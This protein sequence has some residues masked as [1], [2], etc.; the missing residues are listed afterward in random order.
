MRPRL[1]LELGVAKK[2]DDLHAK[3]GGKTR[4]RVKGSPRVPP[5]KTFKRLSIALLLALVVYVFVH[6]IPTDLGPQDKRHPSYVYPSTNG[7]PGAPA[8]PISPRPAVADDGPSQGA[9]VARDY[10]GPVRFLELA[11]TLHAITDTKGTAPVNKNVLFM[12]STL[13]SASKMLPIACEMGRELRSYVHFALVSRDEIPIKQ[14][15]DINGIGD[16]CQMIYHDARPEFSSMSTDERFEKAVGRSLYHINNYMHPQAVIVDSEAE[17]SLFLKAIRAQ[18]AKIS[19]SAPVIELPAGAEERLSWL[20]KL[21]AASLLRWNRAS[22]DILIHAHADASGSLI[23]LLKSLSDADYSACATPH[24][25][26]ELPEKIDPPTRQFLENFQWPPRSIP[27]PT[28]LTQLTLRHRISG[29]GLSEEESSVQFL[30]SFWPA[31]PAYSHVL[32]LSPQVELSTNYFH[33]LKLALLEYHYSS[34]VLGSGWDKRLLGISLDLPSTYLSGSGPFTAPTRSPEETQSPESRTET[35]APGPFLWQ[36]PNS[37]AMLFTG[38]RWLEL[39]GFVSRSLEAQH[40]AETP[41][42]LLSEKSVS[43]DHPAWL[44]HVLRLCRAQGYWTLYPS[45]QLAANLA[46]VHNELYREPEEYEND[47]ERWKH[48]DGDEIIIHQQS[49]RESLSSQGTLPRFQ[50][51][52]ALKWDGT[53]TTVQELDD[54]A[55]AYSARFRN[56]V[57]GCAGIKVPDNAGFLFCRGEEGI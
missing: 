26:I 48:N 16:D 1:D 15:R 52:P 23:R 4:W 29:R 25:T 12:A 41:P 21:D 56:T 38:A 10:D 40:A 14:L 51:M 45:P 37:N 7:V 20:T 6:N 8:T 34:Q 33:Y 54:D 30:E 2:D 22:V 3:G 42:A 27:N 13:K 32:V 35:D 49:L 19:L 18:A 24:L 47:G 28:G 11:E 50:A 55:A 5:R 36:A 46:T 39:H 53:K 9:L 43:K 31:N 44:E 57:G 17:E